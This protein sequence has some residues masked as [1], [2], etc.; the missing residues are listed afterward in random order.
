MLRTWNNGIMECWNDGHKS[1]KKLILIGYKPF[2]T[3]TPILQE[4]K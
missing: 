1:R 4:G 2:E 3:I